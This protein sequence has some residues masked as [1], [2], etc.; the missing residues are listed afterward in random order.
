MLLYKLSVKEAA[1]KN[2]TADKIMS[3]EHIRWET[4]WHLAASFL[5]NTDKINLNFSETRAEMIKRGFRALFG[6]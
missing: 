6:G 1:T 2:I 4:E 3:I 5:P